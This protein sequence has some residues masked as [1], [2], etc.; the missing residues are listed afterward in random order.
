[1]F[2]D[3]QHGDTGARH[4][5]GFYLHHFGNPKPDVPCDDDYVRDTASEHVG[6]T[7]QRRPHAE[8]RRAV[9]HRYADHDV[10]G[11]VWH[12]DGAVHVNWRLTDGTDGQ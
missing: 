2:H 5:D 7:D 8:Q 10:T 4:L 9:D 11:F 6:F 3:G 12:H 1:L